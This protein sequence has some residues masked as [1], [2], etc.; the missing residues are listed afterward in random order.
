[1]HSTVSLTRAP[2]VIAAADRILQQVKITDNPF[3]QDLANGTMTLDVF[4][5]TQEQFSFA[6]VYFSRPM[7]ALVSRIPDPYARANIL[8]NLV[9]EHGDFQADAYHAATI[10]RFV[11]TIG[12][13]TDFASLTPWPEVDAFNSV[14][15]AACALDPVEVGL[16]CLGIIEY[17]FIEISAAI[18]NASIRR[19]W[20]TPAN[21]A[22]YALHTEIDPR[23]AE[24]FFA[25]VE[26]Q[27]QTPN[28]CLVEQGLE[29]GAY[30]WDRL[31]RDLYC[32]AAAQMAIATSGV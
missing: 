29:L 25:L 28:R 4:R 5:R 12:G 13:N 15:M 17:G 10:C 16:S 1:M 21:L 3:F 20:V 19:G 8:H 32:K 30:V 24:D 6:V 31:Y 9:E 18:A 14:L 23:H 22:H 26:P 11:E 27:W 7:A 2:Q